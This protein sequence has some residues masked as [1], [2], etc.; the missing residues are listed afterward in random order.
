MPNLSSDYNEIPPNCIPYDYDNPGPPFSPGA[1]A[2]VDSIKAF[3]SDAELAQARRLETVYFSSIF[4]GAAGTSIPGL[5]S[6]ETSAC[7]YVTRYNDLYYEDLMQGFIDR[8][9]EGCP[10]ASLGGVHWAWFRVTTPDGNRHY[11]LDFHGNLQAWKDRMAAV[12]NDVRTTLAWF[13]RGKFC[14]T[15]GRRFAFGDLT[16]DR[17]EGGKPIPDNW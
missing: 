2:A 14:L 13:D 7:L 9:Y 6:Y 17:L 1:I 16:I 3:L 4:K 8:V 10:K 12:A 15:D 5:R 11:P